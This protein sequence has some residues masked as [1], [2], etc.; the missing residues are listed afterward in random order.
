MR[1][2]R[3]TYVGR[4][5]EMSLTHLFSTKAF[6]TVLFFLML[7][8]IRLSELELL[9]AGTAHGANDQTTTK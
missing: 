1:N 3:I 8:G 4:L 7:A 5:P 2:S 9:E 6:W